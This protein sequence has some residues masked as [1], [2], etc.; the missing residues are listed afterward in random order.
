MSQQLTCILC[1][2]C[3]KRTYVPRFILSLL[4]SFISCCCVELLL[5][6]TFVDRRIWLHKFLS[7]LNLN[8]FVLLKFIRNFLVCEMS[9]LN[10]CEAVCCLLRSFY[11]SELSQGPLC[12]RSE[13]GTTSKYIRICSVALWSI[14]EWADVCAQGGPCRGFDCSLLR[15]QNTCVWIQLVRK[16]NIPSVFSEITY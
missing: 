9:E 7:I 16:V 11:V 2:F 3:F 4:Y 14:H 6:R 1:M 15:K 12:R 10:Y 13:T 8:C 5:I